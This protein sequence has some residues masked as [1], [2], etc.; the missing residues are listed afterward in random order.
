MKTTP[1]RSVEEIAGEYR[2]IPSVAVD[3]SCGNTNEIQ[4]QEVTDWLTQTLQ[5]ERQKREEMVEV[6]HMAGYYSCCKRDS[7]YSEARNYRETITQ[8]NNPK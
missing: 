6:A 1:E 4:V 3:L 5:A 2:Q 7:S 8:P